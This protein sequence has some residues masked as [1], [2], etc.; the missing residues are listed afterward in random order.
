VQHRGRSKPGT[1]RLFAPWGMLPSMKAGGWNLGLGL[2]AFAAGYSGQF[3]LPGTSG[4][5]PLMIAGGAL[6]AFGF[7][8]LWRT[9]H[10]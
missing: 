8:Q 1:A 4:P 3:A 6:A 2:V 9:R 7:F 5:T 10:T